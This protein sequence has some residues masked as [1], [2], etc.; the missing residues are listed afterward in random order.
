MSTSYEEG[1]NKGGRLWD[2]TPKLIDHIVSNV[3]NVY[4]IKP[5]SVLSGVSQNNL[6]RW[7][8]RGEKEFNN[9]EDTLCSQLW[10]R[11]NA[12]KYADSKEI[13]AELKGCPRNYGA[14]TFLLERCFKEEFEQKSDTQKQLEDI[15]FNQLA[16]MLNK[17]QSSDNKS[18]EE[19]S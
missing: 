17:D 6:S 9:D 8:I 4:F 10:L 14:L 12:A 2:L 13:V 15:V 18:D 7:L 11:Y 1:R 5:V 3:P 16:P 19:T